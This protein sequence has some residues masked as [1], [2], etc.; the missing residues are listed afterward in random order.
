MYLCQHY[1]RRSLSIARRGNVVCPVRDCLKTIRI[2]LINSVSPSHPPVGR[3]HNKVILLFKDM[4]AHSNCFSGQKVEH[5]AK[6]GISEWTELLEE[7]TGCKI[8]LR[9]N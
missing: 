4:T 3:A 5:K 2:Q 8:N 7:G 1:H 6:T 9:Q